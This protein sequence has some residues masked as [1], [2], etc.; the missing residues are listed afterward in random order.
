MRGPVI[1][2]CEG[3]DVNLI[4]HSTLIVRE[5][6]KRL[7]QFRNNADIILFRDLLFESKF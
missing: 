1:P 5:I 3:L 6:T 7:L 4:N 2:F